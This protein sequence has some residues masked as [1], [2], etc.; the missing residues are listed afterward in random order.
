MR[1]TVENMPRLPYPKKPFRL[2]DR[3]VVQ[4][5]S[6]IDSRECGHVVARFDWILQEGAYKAPG[7]DEIPVKLDTGALIYMYKERLIH[8]TGA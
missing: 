4:D 8:L 6:G 3:V 2:G 1:L 5:L 7:K